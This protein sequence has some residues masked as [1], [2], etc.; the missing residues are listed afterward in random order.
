MYLSLSE[1]CKSAN[2]MQTFIGVYTSS[3]ILSKFQNM[4]ESYIF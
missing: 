1:L 2:N 3:K 4:E